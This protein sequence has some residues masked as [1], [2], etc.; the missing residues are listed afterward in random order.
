MFKLQCI[1]HQDVSEQQLKDIIRIKTVAWNY[2]YDKQLQWIYEHLLGNDIHCLLINGDEPLA[3][4]NLVDSFMYI[5]GQNTKLYGIGNV[6]STDVGKG[7]G[8]LLMQMVNEYIV[9]QSRVGLLFCKNKLVPFYSKFGWI[10]VEPNNYEIPYFMN[11]IYTMVF[12]ITSDYN[13][14][15]YTNPLF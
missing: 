9:A 1:R 6:C 7:Y 13:K 10:I 5:D 15:E 2:P 14:L 8:R 3:Y 12:N 4:M 11:D